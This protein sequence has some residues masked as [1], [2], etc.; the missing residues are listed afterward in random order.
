M[1]KLAVLVAACAVALVSRGAAAA[2]KVSIGW[3]SADAGYAPWFYARDK[4][5]FAKHGIDADLVFFDSGTKGMQALVA[6]S[7]DVE[8]GDGSATVNARIA[9]AD[10]RFI[11]VTMPILSGE[12]IFAKD[13]KTAQDLKGKK[14][15]I[16]SFG[17]EAH[18]AER[19]FLHANGLTDADVTAVQLGNQ[20]NRAAG[21]ESGAVSASTFLPPVSNR[22]ES[23]GYPPIIQLRELAPNY[24]SVGVVT[25]TATVKQRR[26]VMKAFLESMAEAIHA[27]KNDRAGGIE[28][29][30]K[31]VKASDADAA[32]SYDYYAPFFPVNLRPTE[33]SVQFLLDHSPDA[34]AK[35]MTPKDFM[36]MSLLDELDEAGFFKNLK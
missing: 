12:V 26:P 25:T 3:V 36:D 16:S 20:G 8:A 21:L 23:L 28:L 1:N 22:L 19:L 2:E 4:G 27:L 13:I 24:L 32:T 14:W 11:G 9:G 31:Y 6:G 10:L 30:Q 29:I 33:A 34:K 5:Y 7:V 17:S 18:L 35:T 15:A